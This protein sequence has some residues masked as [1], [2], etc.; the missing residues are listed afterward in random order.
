M[1]YWGNIPDTDTPHTHHF[2]LVHEKQKGT[3]P[4]ATSEQTA[5]RNTR[6]QRANATPAS[7]TRQSTGVRQ[8]PTCAAGRST[9]AGKAARES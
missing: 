2:D 9:G 8:G 1:L 4:Y 6:M 3:L 5:E 7:N